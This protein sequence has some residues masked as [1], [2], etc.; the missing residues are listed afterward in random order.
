[1]K[2]KYLAFIPVLFVLSFPSCNIMDDFYNNT[3]TMYVLHE[4][5]VTTYN[6]GDAFTLKGL[7]LADSET[8]VEITNYSSS[9]EEGYIFQE[10]DVGVKEVTISCLK[11]KY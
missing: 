7:K 4:A 2:N 11:Y 5:D 3:K 8:I 1:M 6:I 9:I 10:A